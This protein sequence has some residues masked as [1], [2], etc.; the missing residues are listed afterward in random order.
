MLNVKNRSRA[1]IV[2]DDPSAVELIA[3]RLQQ[4]FP[5][6]NIT[7][8][9]E[10]DL[11]GTFDL[12]LID[13]DFNG[14]P[15]AGELAESI[16]KRHPESLIIVFSARLDVSVLKRLI[17]AGC[18]GAFDKSEPKELED[19]LSVIDDFMKVYPIQRISARPG[20]KTVELVN[21]ISTLLQE[22]NK[23]LVI[24]ETRNAG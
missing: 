12:Y 16:K 14:R 3:F 4:R 20:G 13:N 7:S 19:M 22:W 23:R 24:E 8:R 1:L 11:T 9:C 17:N 2:D 18:I 6:L 15:L 10:P 21:S 5:G